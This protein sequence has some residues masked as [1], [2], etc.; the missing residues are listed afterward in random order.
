MHWMLMSSQNSYV[1][2]PAPKVM[3]NDEL[4][5]AE[6][7]RTRSCSVTQPCQTLCNPVD[8][9]PP[10]SSLYGIFQA[11][12]PE[13]VARYFS[14]GSSQCMDQAHISCVSCIGRRVLY[15]WATK[16]AWWHQ[17]PYKETPEIP[18]SFH[19]VR[20]Q[21]QSRCPQTRTLVFTRLQICQHLDLGLL[22][23]RTMRN[24]YCLSLP[25]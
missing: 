9:S 5:R 16:E 22:A 4:R 11:R 17:R 19:Y 21:Q 3:G 10:G 6:P 1:E 25:V 2:I 13:W 7:S 14:R 8:C 15:H 12:I 23:S 20:T 18:C 24:V